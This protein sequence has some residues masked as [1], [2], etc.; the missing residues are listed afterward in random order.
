MALTLDIK[1]NDALEKSAIAT[2]VA[3]A[4]V[5]VYEDKVNALATKNAQL[6]AR[7]AKEASAL[8][9]KVK[10]NCKCAP[11]GGSRDGQPGGAK[12]AD[13]SAARNTKERAKQE[14]KLKDQVKDVGKAF[15]GIAVA[16]AAAAT[17]AAAFGAALAVSAK[18]AGDSKREAKALIDAFSGGRGD[19]ILGKL[20]VLAQALGQSVDDVRGK[21]VEFRQAGLNIDFSG[22]LI[23]MRAD[24]M[25]L[26]L[27]A[28]AADKEIANV[29]A[30]A[31]GR[32]NVE[33][34]R[35][36][37]ELAKAYKGAG[38]GAI[39]AKKSLETFEG[40]SNRIGNVVA[41]TL[42]DV[43]TRIG[44][45]IGKAANRLADFV[46]DVLKSKEGKKA[47][48]ALTD[49]FVGLAQAV[50]A[51]NMTAVFSEI[52][53]TAEDLGRAVRG[54]GA[55]FG[56]KIGLSIADLFSAKDQIDANAQV[57]S[58]KRAELAKEAKNGPATSSTSA[59]GA[60][61]TTKND[62]G[63][64]SAGGAKGEGYTSSIADALGRKA[65]SI[66][67]PMVKESTETITSTIAPKAFDKPSVTTAA[68]TINLTINAP[69]GADADEYARIMRRELQLLLQAG[70]LSRGYT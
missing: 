20:D 9:N 68:P 43:W 70:A 63:D 15:V 24:I 6:Y 46:T 19:V 65:Q 50:T 34:E 5:A 8:A 29:T 40:G 45:E 33:A 25:A 39:A 12:L 18:H 37:R 4:R 42:A 32:Y 3:L 10:D 35:K 13:K 58:D 53:K 41:E 47:I 64:K 7:S 11:A 55:V 1:T 61:A 66:A 17:A 16:T 14:K 26:G 67:M 48:D 21:F 56:G 38:S 36:L 54:L 69:P 49:A 57:I 44:P 31:D 28:A 27:S 52:A 30:A 59:A 62:G 60:K 22:R 23:K 51:K 2:A